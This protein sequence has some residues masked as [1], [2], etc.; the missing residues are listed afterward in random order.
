MSS[1]LPKQYDATDIEQRWA[2]QWIEAGCFDVS[3]DDPR[4]AFSIVI[5]PPNITGTLHMGHA[6]VLT[7]QDSLVRFKRMQG[8][9]TLWLPGSDH[10]GIAT[11]MV[12]ERA[13]A[14]EGLNRQDMGREAFV[15]KIWEWKARHGSRI[16]EQTR[17]MG[18][19]V[20]WRRERFTMDEG[21]STAVREVFVRLYQEGLIYRDQRLINWCPRCQTALSDLE[22]V[23]EPTP[24]K[25]WTIEYPV[26]GGTR[27]LAVATTRPETMLGDTAVA[28]HPDDPRY[29]DLI[30]RE[31]EL[32]LTG[33]RIPVIGDAELV[34]PEFGTGCVKVT[35]AHD[36][37]DFETG[38]RH[39]LP[40]ISVI[41]T[42]GRM[43]EAAGKAFA[44]MD[45]FECRER[46][47]AALQEQG[48]LS[49]IA[50]YATEISRCQRCNE[51]V[52]PLLSRQWFVRMEPLARPAIEAVRA[53]RT[54]FVPKNWEKTYFD[55]MENIRDW[56]ISRQLWWG[57]RI[58]AWFC[59]CGE[60]V[61]SRD[62]PAACPRCGGE[63]KQDEDVLDTWFSSAL[64]PFSTLG[65]PERTRA[66]E[67]FYPTSLMETGFDIIFFWVARMMMMGLKFMG[68]VPF[69]TVYLHAM[70]RDERGQKMS[71][72]KGNVIDPLDIIGKWGADALRFAL[73]S[74][75]AQGRDIKLSL[76]R[77]EG[78]RHFVNKIWNAARFGLLNLD[79]VSPA[80]SRP[81]DRTLYDRWILSR[82]R[83]VTVEVTKAMEE[84]RLN[85]ATGALYNF[86]WHELCDWYLELAKPVFAGQAGPAARAESQR[87]L[88]STL[89][90]ALRLLHPFVPFVT[91]EIWQRLPLGERPA[92]FL[93]L[94]PWPRAEDYPADEDAVREMDHLIAAVTGVRTIRGESN[95]PPGQLL[96]AK[97]LTDRAFVSEALSRHRDIILRLARL[98]SL[99]FGEPGQRPPQSA[100]FVTP[101]FE[102][103]VSL[104]GLIDFE[105]EKRRLAKDVQKCEQ[106]ERRSKD[107]LSNPSFTDRA[108][109]EIVQKERERLAEC[110]SRLERL[111][112]ALSQIEAWSRE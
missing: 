53:G 105:A 25:L 80:Q 77:V 91:E 35:P 31:V 101:D 42:R 96:A 27:R 70:V 85:D 18:A 17:A 97:V 71:K 98:E 67:K 82:C 104:R 6:L 19:S 39:N 111:R 57:H 103:C 106:E 24:G 89:D 90:C 64:W 74:M 112:R 48:L 52:E 102:V 10:A 9:A 20:D 21:L 41:D 40:R 61:V 22:V 94:A 99:E 93:A 100:V 43:T 14:K 33:R 55:W 49:K 5:P 72:T 78:Y 50:D 46:V 45:R 86:F 60:I 58:P 76:E 3:D 108:P 34:D 28:V 7:I 15:Q 2:R 109:A 32:P 79:G 1:E 81:S 36:F 59:A 8:F 13:L 107:K 37:S 84:Y 73:A 26:P 23:L 30:G 63:L 66:L 16:Q 44:G 92:R 75:A 56:C 68:D 83:A 38:R 11:Q 47:V 88:L 12:V 51:I 95:L 87:V 29:R 4:P 110:Q 54:N 69:R 65:W 62:T